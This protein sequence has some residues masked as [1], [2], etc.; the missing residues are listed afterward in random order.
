MKRPSWQQ[1]DTEKVLDYI[2]SH[3]GVNHI[4]IEMDLELQF[5]QVKEA[6]VILSG[7]IR[8]IQTKGEKL[9]RYYPKEADVN[10]QGAGMY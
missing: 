10:E 6:L 1:Q 5:W 7:K 9:H 8:S 3:P 2:Q 4:Q